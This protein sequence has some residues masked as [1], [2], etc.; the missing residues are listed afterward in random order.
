MKV[1]KSDHII[2]ARKKLRKIFG[3]SRDKQGEHFKLSMTV[4]SSDGSEPITIIMHGEGSSGGKWNT[5]FPKE[6]K[7]EVLE[8]VEMLKERL[9]AIEKSV[10][11]YIMGNA[12]DENWKELEFSIKEAL[13][14]GLSLEWLEYQTEI[15]VRAITSYGYEEHFSAPIMA[16]AYVT[17]GTD[18]LAKNDLN[19]ASHC[20]DRGL[21][22]SSPDMF[23]LNPND[24][25]T[26]RAGTGG[27]GKSLRH[28]P[29]KDKVA[30]LLEVAPADGWESTKAAIEAV[31][32]ELIKKYSNVV[33][34]CG[35]KPDNLPR[36]ILGWVQAQPD[37][38]P[39]RRFKA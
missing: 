9:A 29:V 19:H 36:T 10:H 18:A 28:E 20:V 4:S 5:W 14:S 3:T 6:K 24:R 17:E 33:E 37:R 32:G 23:I 11:N 31:S 8:S 39:H 38:F 26:E 15:P 2:E 25:F 27:R 13:K 12:L 30:E 22:W 21:Y 7:S 1:K 16:T 34:E 35:L